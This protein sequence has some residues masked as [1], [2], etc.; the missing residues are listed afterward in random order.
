MDPKWY[1]VKTKPLNEP[2][3]YTRL[4]EAGFETIYPKILKKVKRTGRFDIRPLFPTYLFVRFA[5]EQLRTVRYTRGV[6]RVISFGAEPQEVGPEIVEAVRG[7]MDEEGIVKLVKP[8]VEWKPGEK[9]K[10]GE[11]PF[12]G[13]DAIFVEALPDRERVVLLLEAV[14]SFRVILKKEVIEG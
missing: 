13:L 14:S 1:L 9:I 3:I 8:P 5:M 10:I 12:A 4:T 2:R 6:A 7:R 11:G